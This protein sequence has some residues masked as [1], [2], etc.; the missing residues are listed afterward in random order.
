MTV[1]IIGVS[2]VT[3]LVS[4]SD[5]IY[6]VK[7]SIEQ[8]QILI[9]NAYNRGYSWTDNQTDAII[10]VLEASSL[11][12]VYYIEYLDWKRQSSQTNLLHQAEL[13]LHK[14]R[15]NEIDIIIATDDIGMQ[16]AI[17]Y[18]EQLSPDAPIVF[19][20][21]FEASAI[22][23]MEGIDNITGVYESID[24]YGTMEMILELHEGL[25][26]IY[27]INDNSETGVDVENEILTAV[28]AYQ[29]D[30]GYT[31]EHLNNH[32]Y[33]ELDEA[34]K[35]PV[36][37]SIVIMGTH[38][39]DRIGDALPNEIFA[40][41]LASWIDIPMYSPYEFVF[42]HGIVGGSLLS[43]RLQGVK[44]AELALRILDGEPADDIQEFSEKTVYYG[45]D[46]VYAE[47]YHIDLN[48]L[49]IPYNI[50]NKPVSV[51]EQYRTAILTG[52]GIIVILSF[53]I[54]MLSINVRIRKKAQYQLELKHEELYE[55][56]VALTMSEEELKV[57][58]KA[59]MAKQNEINFLAYFDQL[60]M[61]PN[62]N[63]VE[64][65]VKRMIER[66]SSKKTMIL[67]IDVDNFNY[68]NTA[69]GH[70]F[71]DALLKYIAKQLIKLRKLGYYI[72]RLAGDEFFVMKQIEGKETEERFIGNIDAIFLESLTIEGKEISV[73]KSVGYSIYPDDG[74]D[75]DALMTRTDMAKKKMKQIGRGMTSRF[76]AS[77]NQE[78]SDRIILTRAL[79]TAIRDDE[80]YVVFQPQ[81]D[82]VNG[83]IVGLESLARWRSKVVGEVS[84]IV[85]IP[86]AEEIGEII[87]IGYFILD[88]SIKFLAKNQKYF[89]PDFRVSVNISVL[90][91]LRQDFIDRVKALIQIY[92]I[93]PNLLEF[94]ITESVLIES[95]EIIN[96]R[97]IRLKLMGI[98]IALD[99]F[100]TG[101][102]SLTYLEKLPISTL[103]IDKTFIDGIILEGEAH[104]FTKSIIEIAKRLGIKV[105]AEGVEVDGQVD[106]LS[107][108]SSPIIQGYWFSKAVDE[109]TAIKLYL[110]HNQC[111]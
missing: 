64:L 102:S 95:F 18:R 9:I 97:L 2:I 19:T 28:L 46:Y 50:I 109:D 87:D 47:K 12:P 41:V 10:E 85:F 34:L 24:P 15:K 42:D 71:G 40:E 1:L 110:S 98:T 86:L 25:E 36:K 57:Q 96:Q 84:P 103:K 90:Q 31:F 111:E 72:G 23:R 26:H 38:N 51:F 93:P 94:E 106:Y 7:A 62:R 49:S 3:L 32:T 105:V 69:Y 61:L 44:G 65:E 60:T 54:A 29:E 33:V 63:A 88:K 91:L 27:I 22:K 104:F 39:S 67:I 66:H 13:L 14:Y 83:C 55:T 37:N 21:V 48:K 100:G 79:K 81:Y 5:V 58:N 75:Y 70:G 43:G 68:I 4:T 56:N 20:A 74:H 89:A 6:S 8:P 108:C 82:L 101:Y 11:Q 107:A 77:M 35:D 80:L 17:D 45:I 76:V 92:D 52:L 30:Y 53:F 16:F 99:D 59:L 78:M 73:S